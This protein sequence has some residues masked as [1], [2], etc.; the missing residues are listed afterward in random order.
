MSDISYI[1]GVIHIKQHSN[2]VGSASLAYA[3]MAL[4]N[5]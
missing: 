1:P 4:L 5:S 3:D 2:E